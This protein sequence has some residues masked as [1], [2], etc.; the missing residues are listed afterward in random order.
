MHSAQCMFVSKK[1]RRGDVVVQWSPLSLL[2]RMRSLN[3]PATQFLL[4]EFCMF[5]TRLA[6]SDNRSSYF[7]VFQSQK[8]C[9]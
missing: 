8:F 9:L 3:K 7:E 2:T 5:F 4:Q 1:N 6:A